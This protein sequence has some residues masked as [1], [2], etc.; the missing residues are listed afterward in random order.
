[1]VLNNDNPERL[2]TEADTALLLG[3]SPRT[4]QIW[5]RRGDGPP[6]VR[7][8]TRRVRYQYADI[9]AWA[10]LHRCSP[11]GSRAA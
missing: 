3:Y 2:L 10:H 5:R 9:L 1:M 7:L 8:S 4:L 11:E 6:F